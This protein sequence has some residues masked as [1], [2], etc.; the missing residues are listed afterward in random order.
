MATPGNDAS[1]AFKGVT[2]PPSGTFRD[3]HGGPTNRNRSGLLIRSAKPGS[4]RRKRRCSLRVSRRGAAQSVLAGRSIAIE[5]SHPIGQAPNPDADP[6]GI[7]AFVARDIPWGRFGRVEE[8]A[9]VV[10]F[11][12]SPS[13]SRAGRRFPNAAT[14]S[15]PSE[16]DPAHSRTHLASLWTGKALPADRGSRFGRMRRW[17]R[18]R[19]NAARR[20]RRYA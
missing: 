19:A 16:N 2:Q 6:E 13:Q 4:S 9:D 1:V 20:S 7:A 10:T 8:I 15:I 14:Q 5:A 17:R 11:A 12:C 18:R 3:G